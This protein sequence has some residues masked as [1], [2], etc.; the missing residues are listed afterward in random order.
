MSKFKTHKKMRKYLSNVH[1]IRGAHFQC[2]DTPLAKLEYK[3]MKTVGSYRLH[4]LGTPK[5]LWTD[6]QTDRR[7]DGVDTL[8]DLLSLKRHR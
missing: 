7:T 3:G 8:L 4:K 1:N 6:D 2:M 5:V